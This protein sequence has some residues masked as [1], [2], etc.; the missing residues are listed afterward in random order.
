TTPDPLDLVALLASMRDRGVQYVF[1]EVSAHAAYLNKVAGCRFAAM[2]LTNLTQYHLDFFGTMERYADA[3]RSLFDPSLTTLGIVNTDDELGRSILRA[4]RVPI[5]SYGLYNPA[6]VF[7]ILM[8]EGAE[9]MDFTVNAYDMIYRI[10]TTLHGEWS[11]YNVLAVA[12]AAG[13]FGIAPATVQQVLTDIQVPGRF[14][15][16]RKGGVYYVIDYAHTPDGLD[17]S[18]KTARAMTSGKVLAVFG[19]GGDRDRDKRAKMG[20]IASKLADY[21]IV[22]SD[23]PRSEEPLAIAKD[24]GAGLAGDERA[25]ICLDRA[26]AIRLAAKLA[27]EGDVVLIAGKGAET[28]ME[29]DGERVPY[30]DYEVVDCL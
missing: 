9:G 5:L 17:K 26:D 8:R 24:I 20:R 29:R 28:Y 6:D 16:V 10:R 14:S 7:A 15:V 4:R 23:N 2:I 13:Y 1:L 12:T 18:L 3:K 22:T 25:E 21:V 19:C 27:G 11:V 30:S